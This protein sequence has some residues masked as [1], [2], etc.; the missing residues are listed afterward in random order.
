MRVKLSTLKEY[1]SCALVLVEGRVEDAREAYPDMEDETFD[2]LAANQPGGSNNKYLNWSCKQVDDGTMPEEVI[3]A[4]R[5]FHDNIQ[6][7]K[8]K[9]INQYKTVDE[10]NTAIDELSKNKTKSQGAKQA[11]ADTQV[12]YNDDNWLVVRPWTQEASCKYGAGSKWCISAT[13]SRNYFNQYSVTNNKFYFV[14][15][16]KATGNDASSKYAIAIIATGLAAAGKKIQVYDATDR[17]VNISV[18]AKHVGDKW[19]EIWKKIQEHVTA[20]NRTREVEEA[21]KA[22]ETLVNAL[23]KGE[24]LGETGLNRIAKSARLTN[25][26]VAAILK[27]FE[28]YTG[29]TDYRDTRHD[30]MADLSSRAADMEPQAAVAVMKWIGS[31]RPEGVSYWSGQYQLENMLTH[32]NLGP[33]QFRELAGGSDEAVLANMF[34][35]PNVPDDVKKTI[36]DKTSDFKNESNR[37]KVYW[38]LIQSGD[39]TAEQMRAAMNYNSLASTILYNPQD[40]RLSPD[41]IKMIPIKSSEEFQKLLQIPNV[42]SDYAATVLSRLMKNGK[43]VKY[44]LYHILKTVPLDTEHI[45]QLWKDNKSQDARTAILQNPAI[46]AGNASTFSKSKNSAYRFAIAHNTVASA[47]TLE[48]LAK[49]D[50]VSTR[51][52]VGANPQASQETLKKLAGDEAIAV[53][54]GVASNAAASRE[55]LTALKKDSDEFVR[56]AVRKTLKALGVT[57]TIVRMMSGMRSLMEGLEDEDTPD[58]MTPGWNEINVSSVHTREWIAIFLL[59]NNG[60]ATREEVEAAFQEWNP[61]RASTRYVGGRFLRGY[62]RR[63]RE[64][65]VP[66][67]NIWQI[68]KA[69]EPYGQTSRTTTSGGRGWWWSPPGI[70]KGALLRLTPAGAAAAMEVL[71]RLRPA[72]PNALGKQPSA[73][74]KS[75]PP[76]ELN[77]N[78]AE[79]PARAPRTPGVP[80]TTYK[81]YG[82]FKGAPAA[83]RLKGQAY[84]A[85][86]NTQFKGGEQAYITPDNGKL[87]VKKT[88]SDHTQTWEP[89]E[90]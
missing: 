1:L 52:A 45:E 37:Y 43:I 57:E 17:L 27:K 79:E 59:Q 10:L 86:Q 31:T 28:N 90:G 82:K 54:A 6:R 41:L 8:Q 70:N 33:E 65:N 24:N 77:P 20:N 7:M 66:A 51:A 56:K 80:K 49:D 58:I 83:T 2:S 26:V 23:L 25:Q 55:V 38:K 13:A 5:L 39:I 62:R 36:A 63:G 47:E 29:P 61:Q 75:P 32:A 72:M 9:D 35:N 11:K 78:R 46:G 73:V 81:I 69:T 48:T 88:D 30:I 50:S 89:T 18:V 60:H 53:R 87:K 76:R 74:R 84:I 68:L 44:D 40:A 4:I 22:T 64:V 42:P 14:I 16:K 19:P 3:M 67:M 34:T 21:E 15:D 71:N 12:I 85:P